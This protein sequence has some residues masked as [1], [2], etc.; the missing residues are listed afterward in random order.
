MRHG[1]TP[2]KA[3]SAVDQLRETYFTI[4]ALMWIAQMMAPS[5]RRQMAG[6]DQ[7]KPTSAL[8]AIYA[9]RRA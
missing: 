3:P 6:Y 9:W 2:R 8:L 7:G 4:M 5:T 1:C